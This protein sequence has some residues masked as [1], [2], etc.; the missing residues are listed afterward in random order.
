M[1]VRALALIWLGTAACAPFK[2][3]CPPPI[4]LTPDATQANLDARSIPVENAYRLHL[5]QTAL[6]AAQLQTLEVAPTG[7]ELRRVYHCYRG[8]I[9]CR[10]DRCD[11]ARTELNRYNSDLKG[12]QPAHAQCP[13]KPVYR[14]PLFWVGIGGM[15]VLGT[16]G[17]SIYF[18]VQY[19]L[20]RW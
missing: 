2:S 12:N 3:T 4:W 20:R 9:Y 17:L 11:E 1:Q 13:P 8:V 6:S 5:Q 19:N 10:N 7:P 14:K 18:G 16:I 15:A